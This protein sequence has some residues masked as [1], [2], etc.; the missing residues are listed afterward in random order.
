MV[1]GVYGTLPTLVASLVVSG[2]FRQQQ[3]R[4]SLVGFLEFLRELFGGTR[5]ERDDKPTPAR[6]RHRARLCDRIAERIVNESPARI[7]VLRHGGTVAGLGSLR[8]PWASAGA[9]APGV[10]ERELFVVQGP[11]PFGKA[12]WR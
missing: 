8:L 7:R 4:T 9:P 5:T 6:D 10:P 3:L 1:A 12:T 2:R 11:L